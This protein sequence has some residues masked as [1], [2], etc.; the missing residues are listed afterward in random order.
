MMVLLGD[1]TAKLNSRYAD[2][3]TNIEGSKIDISTAN[4]GFIKS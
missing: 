3:N 1:F 4:L 2:D